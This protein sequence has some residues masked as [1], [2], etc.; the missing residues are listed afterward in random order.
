[1][2]GLWF[3]WG[4]SKMDKEHDDEF[5]LVAKAFASDGTDSDI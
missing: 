1:M 3:P 4:L 2:F 5:L